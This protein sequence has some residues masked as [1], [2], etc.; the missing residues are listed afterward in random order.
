MEYFMCLQPYGA[1]EYSILWWFN[2]NISNI[3]SIYGEIS[4]NVSSQILNIRQW[5]NL[6]AF[7]SN[8]NNDDCPL[9]LYEK[10]SISNAFLLFSLSGLLKQFVFYC[11]VG[12]FR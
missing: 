4:V 1:F 7:I 2:V 10:Y 11:T 5:K 9:L 3:W 8:Q 12:K 6:E